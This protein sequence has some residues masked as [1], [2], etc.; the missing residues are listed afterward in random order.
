L[1]LAHQPSFATADIQRFVD[2]TTLVRLRRIRAPAIQGETDIVTVDPYGQ[3]IVFQHPFGSAPVEFILTVRVAAGAIDGV[4]HM[5]SAPVGGDV[6]I[7]EIGDGTAQPLHVGIQ[8]GFVVADGGVEATGEPLWSAGG[9]SV[10]EAVFEICPVD[11]G[12][13]AGAV[14]AV[15][16][17]VTGMYSLP[18]LTPLFLTKF[19][20]KSCA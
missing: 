11:A 2:K 15:V 19:P 10:E 20:K 4:V 7:M 5:I 8:P 14:V 1:R 3:I 17:D 6:E 12:L 16:R 18:C 13:R 9:K